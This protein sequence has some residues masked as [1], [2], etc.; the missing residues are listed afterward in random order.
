MESNEQRIREDFEKNKLPEAMKQ[1][2]ETLQGAI[3]KVEIHVDWSSFGN[4]LSAYENLWSI[5]EQPMYGVQKV[6]Q[7]GLGHD[8]IK[9]GLKKVVIKNVGRNEQAK[10][11]FKDGT[12]TAY[13]NAAEGAHGTPGW[14]EFEK[15]LNNRL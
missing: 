3:D 5:W 12:L 7:D 6:C 10:A 14:I 13:F 9:K 8:A 2:K 4:N 15:V 11:E 1:Y